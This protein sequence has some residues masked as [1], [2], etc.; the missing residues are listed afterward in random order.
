MA[1]ADDKIRRTLAMLE[2]SRDPDPAFKEHLFRRL[3]ATVDDEEFGTGRRRPRLS[4]HTRRL[5]VIA[6]ALTIA[7]LSWIA[8]RPL[9]ELGPKGE[10]PGAESPASP[11][12]PSEDAKPLR[13][14]FGLGDEAP[15]WSARSLDGQPFDSSSLVG[16]PAAIY[17]WGTWCPPCVGGALDGLE[18]SSGTLGDTVNVVAVATQDDEQA[19]RSLVD[20]DHITT[21]VMLDRS[22]DATSS[23]GLE[24]VPALVLLDAHGRLMGAYL[25]DL[26][27]QKVEG[28]LSA[29]AHGD[30]LPHLGGKTR[31]LLPT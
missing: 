11:T 27:Q 1:M 28:V 8:L 31:E 22:G 3:R 6:A 21:P 29:F 25:G 13:L 19:V 2:G 17:L 20:A 24:G 9:L 7:A 30:P 4:E 12:V 14:S 23:W 10:V 15:S 5:I 26:D 16:T 18:S